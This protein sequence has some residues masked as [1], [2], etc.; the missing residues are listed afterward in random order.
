VI[1]PARPAARRVARQPGEVGI[2]HVEGEEAAGQKVRAH[3]G[4][5]A[6]D[7]V[8]RVQVHEG[9][10]GADDER[11][12]A[13]EAQ[14]A[15]VGAH[16][17]HVGVGDAGEARAA[18][19]EH[20]GRGVDAGD[21]PAVAGERDQRAARAAAELEDRRLAARLAELF[22]GELLVPADVVLAALVLVVV[23]RGVLVVLARAGGEGGGEPLVK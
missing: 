17:L 2:E 15:E 13:A 20:L 16:Q 3:D 21:A 1:L 9:V 11:E 23:E 22:L 7:V 4:E 5:E 10:E 6:L 19:L 12:A 8:A 14:R 18:A